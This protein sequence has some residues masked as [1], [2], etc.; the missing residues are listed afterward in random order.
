MYRT[1]DPDKIVATLVTLEARIRERFPDGSL[2]RVAGELIDVA[3][4]A[5]ARCT[6]LVRPSYGIRAL[7]G[8]AIVGGLVGLA[9]VMRYV[10]NLQVTV[11]LFGVMQGIEAASNLLLLVGAAVLFLV[12]L[13]TR[14]KRHTALRHLH[15]LRSIVHVIDMH[16]LTKDPS[17]LLGQGPP[18]SASPRRTMSPF[19]LSRYLDYCSEMLSLA[20]KIAA[21]YAQS[22]TDPEVIEVVNDIERLTTNLSSKIWQKITLV[23]TAGRPKSA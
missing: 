13:E 1:L 2:A 7:A 15:E 23:E 4:E 14:S 21:L 22:S 10:A 8:L 16:Q 20:A 6:S 12:T 9:L 17:I 11:E 19:E 18:T 5:R 3:R